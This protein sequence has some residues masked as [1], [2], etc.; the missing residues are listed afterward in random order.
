MYRRARSNLQKLYALAKRGEKLVLIFGVGICAAY[1][2]LAF[3]ENFA[4]S[5]K[6]TKGQELFN[7]RW[8]VPFIS[9]GRWGAARIPTQKL[10]I[11][12]TH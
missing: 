5:K 11:H 1:V 3:P 2:H 9:N 10:V 12:V 8:V 4:P 7:T 6:T